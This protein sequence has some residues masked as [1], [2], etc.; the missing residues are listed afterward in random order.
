MHL[1]QD[2]QIVKTYH[3]HGTTF[4]MR[5]FGM[6]F[7]SLPFYFFAA[8]LSSILDK[9][10]MALTYG[11][12][13]LIFGLVMAYD[14]ML[15]YFDRLIITNRRVVH[16]D[17]KSAVKRDEHE[18]EINDIQDISTEETGIFAALPIFDYG[19]FSLETASTKT[20]IIFTEA[21]DPEGIKHFIYHLQIKPSRIGGS[22]L[23][24][25]DDT[26]RQT[27]DEEAAISRRQ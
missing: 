4:L 27:V 10:T 15:Y 9:T 22:H 6:L 12:I 19:T 2:E 23:T 1:N 17:W 26:A 11:G 20:S 14:L 8:L 24:P 21:P 13:T 16:I 18:A 25:I 3:H 5:A 7:V